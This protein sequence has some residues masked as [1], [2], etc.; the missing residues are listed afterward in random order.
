MVQ[1]LYNVLIVFAQ[2]VTLKNA[3]VCFSVFTILITT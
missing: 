3:L 2:S 1:L